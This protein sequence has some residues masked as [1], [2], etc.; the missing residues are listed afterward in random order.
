MEPLAHCLRMR[1]IVN[2]R[3]PQLNSHWS[4]CCAHSTA[5]H[6]WARHPTPGILFRAEDVRIKI[7][8][9]ASY[10]GAAAGKGGHDA[11]AQPS[12]SAGLDS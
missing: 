8:L 3:S 9:K 11:C 4:L 12:A 2:G 1:T 7:V 5:A 6:A 10:Y